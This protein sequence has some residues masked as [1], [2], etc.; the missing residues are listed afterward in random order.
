LGEDGYW[1]TLE[2]SEFHSAAERCFDRA[3][4]PIT[5]AGRPAVRCDPA[6]RADDVLLPANDGGHPDQRGIVHIVGYL[7]PARG[8]LDLDLVVDPA[9]GQDLTTRVAANVVA[10]SLN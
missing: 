2:I 3:S 1:L 9:R 10:Q 6:G 5:V 8:D 7:E 4:T